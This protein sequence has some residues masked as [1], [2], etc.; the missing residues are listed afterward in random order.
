M[1]TN[2]L[3]EDNDERMGELRVSYVGEPTVGDGGGMWKSWKY[4]ELQTAYRLFP[5]RWPPPQHDLSSRWILITCPLMCQQQ[6]RRHGQ[7]ITISCQNR[8]RRPNGVTKRSIV[9]TEIAHIPTTRTR[10]ARPPIR[11][12]GVCLMKATRRCTRHRSPSRH[13]PPLSR[14][15]PGMVLCH[16]PILAAWR[17][18]TSREVS[19]VWPAAAMRQ[20]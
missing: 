17:L 10:Q 16:R 4:C 15:S 7:Q 9:H 12:V 6:A 1:Q 3:S 18:L 11:S 8:H 5:V 14:P 19:R 2:Q 20:A 13:R